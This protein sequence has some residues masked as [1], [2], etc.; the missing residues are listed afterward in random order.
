MLNYMKA[1]L[2]R[3][4]NR[5][6][7][8]GFIVAISLFTIL[9]NGMIVAEPGM[10]LVSLMYLGV[11]LLNAP[12]FLVF[13]IVDMVTNEENK[14]LTLRNVVSFGTSRN[15]IILSKIIVTIIL[16]IIAALIILTAFLG[17]GA[18]IFGLGDGFSMDIVKDFSLRLLGALPLWIGSIAVGTF[19]GIVLKNNT[20]SSFVYFGLFT[21][22]KNIIQILSFF[23]SDKFMYIYNLLITVNLENFKAE[24]ITNDILVRA[25]LLG[26]GYTL[27]FTIL[28][29]VYFNKTEV[30]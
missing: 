12:V 22:L 3:N 9:F 17:S 7:Y 23:I 20:L 24:A 6:Y 10:N 15:K 26:I 14:N 27:L 4:F 8:W 29:M 5:S 30:K 2:Y 11:Q 13:I 18:L 19:L 1:E 25:T 21:I 28:T 16:S